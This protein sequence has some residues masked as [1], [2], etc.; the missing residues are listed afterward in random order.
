[1]ALKEQDLLAELLKKER[2]IMSLKESLEK[3][4]EKLKEQRLEKA[5]VEK[6]AESLE[7]GREELER[8]LEERDSQMHRVKEESEI[9]SE[10]L[11]RRSKEKQETERSLRGSL[12]QAHQATT[13]AQDETQTT[14]Q[15]LKVC[16]R[17]GSGV[18]LQLAEAL[19]QGQRLSNARDQAIQLA[20]QASQE[21]EQA[22]ESART[23]FI[24]LAAAEKLLGSSGQ[25]LDR[26]SDPMPAKYTKTLRHGDE[27]VSLV[28][29]TKNLEFDDDPLLF[30]S[31]LKMSSSDSLTQKRTSK[32]KSKQDGI[33]E[34]MTENGVDESESIQ[35]SK[36]QDWLKIEIKGSEVGA[37]KSVEENNGGEDVETNVFGEVLKKAEVVD[38][39]DE[40]DG[41]GSEDESVQ[42]DEEH[43][44]ELEFKEDETEE[45][46]EE[47]ENIVRDEED[48]E[49]DKEG[50]VKAVDIDQLTLVDAD[51]VGE[52]F[53]VQK[54]SDKNEETEL[55]SLEDNEE[56]E[57]NIG[58]DE[59]AEEQRTEVDEVDEVE[60]NNE[61][62]MEKGEEIQDEGV[63]SQLSEIDE[64]EEEE[65][66]NNENV[67]EEVDEIEE[68]VE[69]DGEE[70]PKE[71]EVVLEF[72]G[73][74]EDMKR[75]DFS[76]EDEKDTNS[77]V[78]ENFPANALSRKERMRSRQT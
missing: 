50:T 1:M 11:N 32:S 69:Q 35:N 77:Q 62:E 19:A 47:T 31:N 18:K 73:E 24:K 66:D 17:E 76:S 14:L 25:T 44:E 22:K 43:E 68:G 49:Q 74:N 36:V 55:V 28:H 48:G 64:V 6:R 60:A 41:I 27:A 75:D 2:E 46:Q 70:S 52:G 3:S 65:V 21:R 5:E 51:E 58:V 33:L 12:T 45:V 37:S 7:A 8:L 59:D 42:K 26:G 15:R 54:E 23:T 39:E 63:R 40:Q 71:D 57:A 61:A 10:E 16:E 78:G 56:K 34:E 38:Q 9:L 20:H 53:F 67:E 72:D 30:E 29:S 13:T 4:E